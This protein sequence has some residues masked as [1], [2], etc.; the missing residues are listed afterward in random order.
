MA[1]RLNTRW[2]GPRAHHIAEFYDNDGLIAYMNKELG[3]VE[4]K[5]DGFHDSYWITALQMV[6]DPSTV[7][8]KER[9][10]AGK[11]TVNGVSIADLEKTLEVGGK[12]MKWR[13]D[14]TVKLIRE[15]TR[16]SPTS[17]H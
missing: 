2:K 11:A 16:P 14:R 9:V 15:T 3:I 13:V 6:T 17:P 4:P 7:R 10:A 12:L 8:Y 5:N 1:A